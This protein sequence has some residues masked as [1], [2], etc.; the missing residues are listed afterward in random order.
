MRAGDPIGLLHSPEIQTAQCPYRE[1]SK[2]YAYKT[3][4]KERRFKPED[5]NYDPGVVIW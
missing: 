2:Y 1:G 3:N 5:W 4:W